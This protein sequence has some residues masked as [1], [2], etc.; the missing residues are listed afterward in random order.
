MLQS[1]NKV[2]WWL[3][4][5]N[6]PCDAGAI[7]GSPFGL[8]RARIPVPGFQDLHQCRFG[9]AI[10]QWP[11]SEKELVLAKQQRCVG[12][13]LGV[14]F[15][16]NHGVTPE[17]I[18]IPVSHQSGGLR[19]RLLCIFGILQGHFLEPGDMVAVIGVS[20]TVRP[21]FPVNPILP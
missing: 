10:W 14:D 20:A 15:L 13:M 16:G 8:E 17:P 3:N 6:N 12:T 1:I 2:C 19:R 9:G 7:R 5:L 11:H 21:W 4:C 18:A